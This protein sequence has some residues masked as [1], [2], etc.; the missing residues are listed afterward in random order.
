MT[1]KKNRLVDK[2]P[3]EFDVG[4]AKFEFKLVKDLCDD[5]GSKCFGLTDFDNFTISLEE[6]MS[7]KSAHHTIIHE[8]CHCF[9]ETFGLGGPEVNE[10][11]KVVTTNEFITEC[12]TR[13]LLMFINLNPILWKLLFEDYHE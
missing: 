13:A 9:C 10:E 8:C 1:T 3:K 6:K 7:I 5:E 4:W 2:L 11:D 12:T